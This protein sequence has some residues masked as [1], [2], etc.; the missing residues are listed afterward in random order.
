[1]LECLRDRC[2]QKI[3]FGPFI[4][5]LELRVEKTWLETQFFFFFRFFRL[6]DNSHTLTG[7]VDIA[8]FNPSVI[9]RYAINN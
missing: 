8:F 1:M 9:V 4:L 6:T 5:P 7:F 2:V 3:F